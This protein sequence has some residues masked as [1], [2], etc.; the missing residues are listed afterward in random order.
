MKS[1]LYLQLVVSL[2]A[3]S[4]PLRA[5][6]GDAS[7]PAKAAAG[8]LVRLTI[9]GAVFEADPPLTFFGGSAGATLRDIVAVIRKARKD[10]ATSGMI[11]RLRSPLVGWTQLETIRR[12]LLELRKA[13]KKS[14]CHLSYVDGRSYLLASACSD[15]SLLPAGV[16]EMPGLSLSRMYMKDLLGKLGIE[17]QELRMGRYKSAAET[18]TRNGPSDAV[19]EESHA[20]VDELFDEYVNSIAENRS[21]QPIVV[22]GLIDRAIFSPKEAKEA[23]LVDHLE[24][25]DEFLSRVKEGIASA[26][27]VDA[28]LGKKLNLQAGGLPGLMTVFNQ[29]FGGPS[30]SRSSKKPKIAVIYG[31]GPIVESG[32]ASLFGGQLLTSRQMVKLFRQVRADE[33][34]KAVVFRVDSPGGSAIASDIILREVKLTAEKKPVV[35]S[36][37]DL[38]ASG[39]YYVSCGATWIVAENSTLTGSI[40]V[41][42]MIPNMKKLY[43]MVGVSYERFS[44][45]K[46]ANMVSPYGELT[47]DGRELLMKYMRAVYEQFLQHVAQGRK[48]PKDAVASI[49]EG[50]VWTGGQALKHGLVD[51][52]GGLETALAKARSLAGLPEDVDVYSLPKPKNLFEILSELDGASGELR[53]LVRQLPVDLR[54]LAGQLEWVQA[55][56]K[57]RALLVLPEIFVIE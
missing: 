4:L 16:V 10:P 2:A 7:T 48:L 15:V 49:A 41:I 39:G 32:Q 17:F 29:I 12:E 24:Y 13:G 31:V 20:I 1:C 43:E 46:L 55:A 21:I 40:G 51:E 28:K 52:L 47:E 8:K 23:G 3:L 6:E 26:K 36:M 56:R 38:A 22:R 25:Q 57:E 33:S 44:R 54:H 35:V 19:R 37:G 5:D 27:I 34:V 50:R 42:G 18:Y 30:R 11:L 14:H 53:M 45:G 9:A